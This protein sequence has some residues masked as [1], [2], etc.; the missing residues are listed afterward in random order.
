MDVKSAEGWLRIR[1]T[2]GIRVLDT[3]TGQPNNVETS[4][5]SLL[6]PARRSTRCSSSS[7]PTGTDMWSSRRK[8]TA[9]GRPAEENKSRPLPLPRARRCERRRRSGWPHWGWDW[10]SRWWWRL[11]GRARSGG[12]G[13]FV[14]YNTQPSVRVRYVCLPDLVGD[15]EKQSELSY[16]EAYRLAVCLLPEHA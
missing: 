1:Y 9:P 13:L 10:L 2:D 16:G 7:L 4:A 14:Q 8:V 3:K 12:D 15:R 11:S 6:P 5:L